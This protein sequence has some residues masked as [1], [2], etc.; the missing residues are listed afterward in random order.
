MHDIS[1]AAGKHLD[2]RLDDKWEGSI[3]LRLYSE[4]ENVLSLPVVLNED[5]LRKFLQNM[6]MCVELVPNEGRRIEVEMQFIPNNKFIED[7]K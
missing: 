2:L 1:A 6:Y 7:R 5:K 3:V 4:T